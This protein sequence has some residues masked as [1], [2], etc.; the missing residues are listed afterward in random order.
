MKTKMSY[1]EAI[2]VEFYVINNTLKVKSKSLNRNDIAKLRA[3][4][5]VLQRLAKRV[6]NFTKDELFELYYNSGDQFPLNK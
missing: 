4:K 6:G 2:K 5:E 3:Q 1:P